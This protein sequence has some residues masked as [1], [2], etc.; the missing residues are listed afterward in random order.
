[1]NKTTLFVAAALALS[2]AAKAQVISF[3]TSEGYTIGNIS[4][5]NNWT[6]TGYGDGTFIENQV[7][8]TDGFTTG[9]QS[10]KLNQETSVAPQQNPVVGAFYTYPTAI[11]NAQATFSADLYISEQN[12]TSMSLMFALVDLVELKYRTYVNFAYDGYVNVL[13]QGATPGIIVAADSGFQWSPETWYNVKIQTIGQTMKL[14]IDG[15][16]IFE[17]QMPS[18]G[19]ISEVRFIHDNYAGFAYVDNFRTNDEE[20]STNDFTSNISFKHFFNQQ[21]QT[22]ALNSTVADLTNVEVY[23]N[24]GQN[25]LTQKLSAQTEMI[26]MSNLAAG[27]YIVKVTA[28][29][30]VKTLKIVKN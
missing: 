11:P 15:T 23:N 2:F 29:S 27:T 1:M 22:L 26:S 25:V 24:L 19:P 13:V 14:F 5:Q 8:S 3:E 12:S 7:I 4:T 10:L 18:N 6:T 30:I 28:G 21:N 20:L 17:G 16:E 9:T